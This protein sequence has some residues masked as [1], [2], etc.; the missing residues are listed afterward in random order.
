MS[1]PGFVLRPPWR[2]E[3]A[4]GGSQERIM[5]GEQVGRG[6][7]ATVFRVEGRPEL[8]AKMYQKPTDEQG[9]KLRAMLRSVPTDPAGTGGHFALA[10]PRALVTDANGRVGG[11]VMPRLDS[12]G[13]RP[14]HQIYHP[15]SR[16]TG[17]PGVGW[18]YLVRVAR[19]LS[20]TIT[21]LHAAG[22]V[23]GDLNESNVL[24]TQRALVTLID[25]DSIQV[26]DGR[27]VY[28]CP[29]GKLEYTPPELIG[30]S[31]RDVNRRPASDV[32]ALGVLVFQLLLE[33][34]HPFSGVW[35]GPGEPPRLENNIRLR[36]SPWFGARKLSPPPAAPPA[37]VP[38]P[39]LRSLFRAT[40]VSPGFARPTAQDWQRG[41]DHFEAGLVT[42]ER[43][44]LH[45]YGGHLRRCPWCE[46]A[47]RLGVDPF[48][49]RGRPV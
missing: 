11:F 33:G 45:A 23:V 26:R 9:A 6:G 14:L 21:A 48:P 7:E 46:R 2:L 42:C 4:D 47:E 19:N 34:A 31:F 49:G 28:R 37:R 40:F 18:R 3:D 32:F 12:A 29:V 17:A 27:K 35:S 15:G 10:W 36:R 20:A 5:L 25:L 38:G 43:N 8:V 13:V 24:V 41:L 44:P 30:R 39:K 1:G 22:Y 16:R